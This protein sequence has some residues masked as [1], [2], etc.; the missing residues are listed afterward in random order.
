MCLPLAAVMVVVTTGLY[1]LLGRR[2]LAWL[3]VAAVALGVATE[4]RN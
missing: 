1:S 3:A 4:Q 2:A